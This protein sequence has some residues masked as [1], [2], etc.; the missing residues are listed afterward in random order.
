MNINVNQVDLKN[1]IEKLERLLHKS[2]IPVLD[3][4]LLTADNNQITITANNL[5]SS[6]T[7]NILGD[8][9]DSGSIL[10]DKSN[11]KLI[12]KLSGI[13]NITSSDNMGMVEVNEEEVKEAV[14]SN[15]IT[16]K[17][18]RNLKFNSILP[19]QFP[20]IPK[21]INSEAFNM[22]ENAFK[23]KLKI[24]VFSAKGHF[25]EVFNGVLI[26]EDDMVANN[27]H[28]LA[29]YK[30]NIENKC[31]DQM[32]IPMQS[33]EELDKIL[34]NKSKKELEFYFKK[35][36]DSK[37]M[38]YIK[39]VGNDFIYTTRL[40]DGNYPNYKQVIP[41]N[42][43]TFIDIKKDQLQDTL[44][45]AMEIV[46]DDSLKPVYLNITKQLTINTPE[47]MEKS[48]SEVVPSEIT[49]EELESI[50][51][52]SSYMSTILKTINEDKVNIKLTGCYSPAVFTGENNEVELYVLVPFRQTA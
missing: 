46:K 44:E 35:D 38:K 48:M 27:T 52:N 9:I 25:R 6:L 47:E 12:K 29:R 4:V 13:L 50:K 36:E 23:N 41:D 19:E 26:S 43:H 42:F 11:F 21:D 30:L 32:N 39:I 7:I 17:A 49:G 8:I 1:A 40:V 20:E 51:F 37:E 45:F 18:N 34:N 28:Y 3:S 31:D 15:T 10:I 22:L 5:A 16:I 2:P 14:I 24:K 33:I